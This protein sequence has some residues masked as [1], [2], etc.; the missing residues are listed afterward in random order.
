[1]L[2]ILSTETELRSDLMKLQGRKQLYLTGFYTLNS[3]T[4]L[5]WK[6]S[7]NETQIFDLFLHH[8]ACKTT[9]PLKGHSRGFLLNHIC[10]PLVQE[11]LLC[12]LSSF[13]I[14]WSSLA[15]AADWSCDR[16]INRMIDDDDGDDDD[17]F[18]ESLIHM[19]RR[20]LKTE[21]RW[22]AGFCWTLL[23]PVK[24]K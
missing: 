9:E 4:S 16:T 8:A 17:S 7:I 18:I 12:W 1:M 2:V 22:S 11:Q 13:I 19:S 24:S 23:D 10:V 6:S 3:L 20:T 15:S 21:F 14:N 5:M